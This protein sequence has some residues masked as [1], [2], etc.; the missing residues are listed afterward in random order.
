MKYNY[1]TYF[2]AW[3]SDS[4]YDRTM[5]FG[6]LLTLLHP[7]SCDRLTN[8]QAKQLYTYLQKRN[9]I[10]V[11]YKHRQYRF[12]EVSFSLRQPLP[13]LQRREYHDNASA[14]EYALDS[15][16]GFCADA[17]TMVLMAFRPYRITQEQWHHTGKF[18]DHLKHR[19]RPEARIVEMVKQDGEWIPHESMIVQFGTPIY[20]NILNGGQPANFYTVT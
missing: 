16:G 4:G 6:N 18:L 2:A 13:K 19:D 1:C 5:T 15:L 7:M 11:K 9:F 10:R 14:A 3:L 17:E 20:T 12:C 8:K